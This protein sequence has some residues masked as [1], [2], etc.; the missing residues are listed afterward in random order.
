MKQPFPYSSAFGFLTRRMTMTTATAAMVR[1]P[2]CWNHGT[3]SFWTRGW[4]RNVRLTFSDWLG[5]DE[6]VSGTCCADPF[7]SLLS[8]RWWCKI[9]IPGAILLL[10][11]TSLRV[12]CSKLWS[13]KD[14]SI[15]REGRDQPLVEI[16]INTSVDADFAK[17]TQ[18]PKSLWF[19]IS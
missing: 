15:C 10:S 4:W 13:S 16:S 19:D 18:T 8:L 6:P 5:L 2:K 1:R 14:T 7:V 12:Y 9:H 3:H 17:V 11:A